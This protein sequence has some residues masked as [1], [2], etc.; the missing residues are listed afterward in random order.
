MTASN[1]AVS[2]TRGQHTV[3]D[4]GICCRF[5]RWSKLRSATQA[6]L[7]YNSINSASNAYAH[8]RVDDAS[9]Y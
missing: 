3:G 7:H 6:L 8:H 2:P 1:S 5:I 4:A 9:R